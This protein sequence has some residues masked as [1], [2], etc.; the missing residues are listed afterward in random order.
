MTDAQKRTGP[1]R[2]RSLGNRLIRSIA[3]A[4]AVCTLAV[5]ALQL[6]LTYRD[7]RQD[8]EAEIRSIARLNVPLL[9]VN[10]WDIEP[11]AIRRQLQLIAERPQIAYVRLEAVTGQQFE[12]GSPTRREDPRTVILDIPYPEGKPGRLGT[13]QLAPNVEHLYTVLVGDVL[14]LLAAFALLIGLICI[15]TSV[16]LRRQLQ[17][18][19][20]HIADF[21]A[22]LTPNDLTRPLTLQRP[23]GRS[24]DEID[25]VADGFRLLQ[26]DIRKHVDQLDHLVAQ[27]TAQLEAKSA[28]LEAASAHKSQFLANMS[29]ELR[30]PLNAIIGVSEMQL[31][32]ARDLGRKDAIEPL[33]RILRAAQHLL[34][35]INDI[36]DLSKIDAGKM[37]VHLESVDPAPLIEEIVATIRPLAEKN[38]NRVEADCATDLG[39]VH[40]DAKR[41]RQALLNL[42]GNAAKFTDNGTIRIAGGRASEN[43]RDWT[44][45]SVSDTGIGMTPQQVSRLFQDFVQA[46]ASTT[47]KY[48][49]TGLGL[50][51]SR[52]FC[53]MMGG[54]ITVE[55]APGR[56]STFTIRLPS[57]IANTQEVEPAHNG[58]TAS[59]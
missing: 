35:L 6:A 30:T 57:M 1:R 9:S 26:A 5:A 8:F 16:I 19:M 15:V 20:Q 41:L 24:R 4:G 42:A 51:I 40:A 31:E 45:L 46:D 58:L 37:E 25:E 36:L 21:A 11:D 54:D 59:L 18:P 55:S 43:G 10:L 44:V 7:H 3:T 17:L 28:E 47:R 39:P 29:H 2:F 32:D 33:E 49:G 34:A 23:P 56:G 48:G 13:L 27:R 38:G 53:R 52:R 50:A 14:R 22:S 12:S